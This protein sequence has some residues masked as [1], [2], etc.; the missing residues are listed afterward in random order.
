MIEIYI[1]ILKDYWAKAFNSSVKTI[2]IFGLIG[3]GL[4]VEYLALFFLEKSTIIEWMPIHHLPNSRLIKVLI[5]L[6][7]VVF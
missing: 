2:T 3:I 6:G 1:S 5:D 7:I 4:L